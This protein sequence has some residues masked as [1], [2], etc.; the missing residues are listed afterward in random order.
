MIPTCNLIYSRT[1]V[2]EQISTG[3]IL[4]IY[5]VMIF[6]YSRAEVQEQIISIVRKYIISI[7][8]WYLNYSR[9]EVQE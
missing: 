7:P 5:T 4:F 2:Q 6:N 1:E 8:I 3:S 9:A